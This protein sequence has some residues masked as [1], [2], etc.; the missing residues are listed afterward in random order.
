MMT[1]T[2]IRRALSKYFKAF[3]LTACVSIFLIA[4]KQPEYRT[5]TEK[6]IDTAIE[7]QELSLKQKNSML[8]ESEKIYDTVDDMPEFPGGDAALL[9]FLYTNIKYPETARKND[10]QG[11]SVVEFIVEKDGS[12]SNVKIL[13]AIGSGIDEEALRVVNLMPNWQAGRQNDETVRVEYKLPIRFKLTDD[14]NTDDSN[15]DD[16]NDE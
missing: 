12:L 16:S 7:Q 11:M 15:T 3:V 5:D 10:I 8:P 13:R 9:N 4:C 2:K 1:T 14:S 6:A